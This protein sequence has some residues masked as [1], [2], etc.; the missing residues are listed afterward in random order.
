MYDRPPL[1]RC[2][3]WREAEVQGFIQETPR[4]RSVA[5]HVAGWPGHAAGQHVDIRLT[6]QE[7]TAERS[8][9]IA[10]AA[11]DAS[12]TLLVARYADGAV[13]RYL[14]SDVRVGDKIQLRGPKGECFTPQPDGPIFLIA[15]GSGIVPLMA[16]LRHREMTASSSRAV[17]LYSSRTADEIIY[18]AELERMTAR[19][20]LRVFHVLTRARPTCWAGGVGRIDRAT[21]AEFGP[22]ASARP[23]VFICGPPPFVETMN[24]F[25]VDLGHDQRLIRTQR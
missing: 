5:L 16:L 8:Y 20:D 6:G 18:R 25:L 22:P 4:A 11:E 15:A 10:S 14:T 3:E 12:V 2:L 7:R 21:L 13:S 19:S 24:H 1:S 17:L 9:S 23:Q